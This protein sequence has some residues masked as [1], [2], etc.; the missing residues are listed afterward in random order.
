MVTALLSSSTLFTLLLLRFLEKIIFW[1]ALLDR[2]GKIAAR[3]RTQ[4]STS[5]KSKKFMSGG[6]KFSLQSF[7]ALPPCFSHIRQH[8]LSKAEHMLVHDVD[9]SSFCRLSHYSHRKVR[10]MPPNPGTKPVFSGLLL[11]SDHAKQAL[12]RFLQCRYH[13]EMIMQDEPWDEVAHSQWLPGRSHFCSIHCH[14]RWPAWVEC[15]H[16]MPRLTMKWCIMILF[17]KINGSRGWHGCGFWDTSQNDLITSFF[18]FYFTD[19]G[20]K[21]AFLS[22]EKKQAWYLLNLL[23]EKYSD[24]D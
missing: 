4:K 13:A 6:F 12:W 11:T 23:Y 17:T 3:T 2:W 14:F 20:R 21:N 7:T 9:E 16:C 10:T 18:H 5:I 19:L 22:G 15:S 24:V 8:L 1:Y